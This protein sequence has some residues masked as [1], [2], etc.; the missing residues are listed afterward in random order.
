MSNKTHHA[1]C[2]FTST[3]PILN[4][5]SPANGPTQGSMLLFVSLRGAWIGGAI[6]ANFSCGVDAILG[7]NT[8]YYM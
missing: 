2:L 7:F 8:G 6:R 4:S 5:I 3:N 1:F